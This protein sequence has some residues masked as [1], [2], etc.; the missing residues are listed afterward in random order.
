MLRQIEAHLIS[1]TGNGLALLAADVADKLDQILFE[2]YGDIQLISR[3]IRV[4]DSNHAAIT[5]YVNEVKET[6]LYYRW[7]GVTDAQGRIVAATDPGDVG[8]DQSGTEWFRAAR[9][10]R[11]VHL[12]DVSVSQEANGNRT[13]GFAAPI[14]GARGEVL[15]VVATQVGLAELE[16]VVAR[17]VANFRTQQR[18]DSRVEWQIMDHTGELLADSLLR[19]EGAVNLLRLGLVS[20]QRSRSDEPGFVEELHDRRGVLVLTGY[21][22]LQG[23]AEFPGFPWSILVRVDRDDTL[24]PVTRVQRSFGLAGS[25]VLVPLV[26]LLVWSIARLRTRWERTQERHRS[27]L[28]SLDAIVWESEPC[29]PF[30]V[31]YVN[32]QVQH[33]LGYAPEQWVSQQVTWRDIIHPEDFDRVVASY[34]ASVQTGVSCDLICRMR[35]ADGQVI[36]VKALTTVVQGYRQPVQFHGVI[37]DVTEQKLS[38]LREAANRAQLAAIIGSAMDAIVAVDADRRIVLFNAAAETIFRCAAADAIGQSLDRFIPERFRALHHAQFAAL[39][40]AGSAI[41]FQRVGRLVTGLRADGEEFSA[42]I[43]LS[44]VE[45]PEGRRYTAVVRDVTEQVR[46]DRRQR[47]QFAVTQI[48]AEAASVEDAMPSILKAIGDGCGWAAGAYWRVEAGT[49]ML[50][51]MTCWHRPGS[52]TG[53]F[54]SMTRQCTWAPGIGLPGRVWATGAPV[55][56]PDVGQDDNLPRA[57]V[58]ETANLRACVGIP[59]LQKGAVVGVLEFFSEQ[60]A[61]SDDL[62]LGALAAIGTQIGLFIERKQADAKAWVLLQAIEAADDAVIL[63][64]AQGLITYLNL[65]AVRMFGYSP[66]EL[67][68]QPASLLYPEAARTEPYAAILTAAQD[69]GW[70]GEVTGL[71]KD[72][73]R[74]PRWLSVSPIRDCEGRTTGLVS[75][76]R[77]LTSAKLMEAQ[78]WRLERLATLGQLLGGIAHELKNPLFVLTGRLQLL[79]E[80]MTLHDEDGAREDLKKIEAAAH[81][82][83]AVAERFLSL[84]KPIPPHQEWCSVEIILGEVLEFLANEFMKNQIRVERVWA[85]DLPRI[86]S[87]PSQLHEVFLNLMLNAVHA[88]V[89]AHGRGT[90]TV[91][92]ARVTDTEGAASGEER[93]GEGDRWIEVRIADDGPGVLPEHRAKL[94]EPFFSTKPPG[95]GTGLG[96]WAVRSIMLTLKGTVS[97]DTEVGRGTTFVVR[98]PVTS[99]ESPQD[100]GT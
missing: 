20:A 16:D 4:K 82:M 45:T 24:A 14:L 66:Q 36:W 76:S 77:D 42:D 26:G 3:S 64:D 38:E 68:G 1:E 69:T 49:R 18:E 32:P 92:T 74:F 59:I 8:Q 73:S 72:E 47:M 41:P 88:M 19:E 37:V 94:F 23:Y 50:S 86:L 100:A 67:I 40:R 6:Y 71:R 90:L 5:Q 48:L 98:L 87:D 78:A 53:D 85:E 63:T 44:A 15:G 91:T 89:G 79:E 29:P 75:V 96:L 17:T 28:H 99:D 70:S 84:A 27:L 13:V 7:I 12:R 52:P 30:R 80:K 61:A 93:H 58:A 46:A 55:W 39:V 34:Q 81:R 25:V 83:T 11:S 31:T 33:L 97:Y 95:K 57:T 62:L 10:G 2:R 35:R 65:A 56:V 43:A 9:E 54:E 51:C 21:A 60:I 22:R